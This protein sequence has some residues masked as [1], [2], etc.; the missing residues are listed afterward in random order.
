ML[1]RN[2][3]CDFKPSYCYSGAVMQATFILFLCIW[4][5]CHKAETHSVTLDRKGHGIIALI[6]KHDLSTCTYGGTWTA[7]GIEV[8]ANGRQFI[9]LTGKPL[10][11]ASV[12][13]K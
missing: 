1:W 5:F 9:H 11:V 2:R 6:R 8:Q 12:V 7:H 3:G 10:A 4:P 13:C